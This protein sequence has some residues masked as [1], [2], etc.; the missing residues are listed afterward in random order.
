MTTDV[1]ATRRALR[2]AEEAAAV[3]KYKSEIEALGRCPR[4]LG[5][6]DFW[7][8]VMGTCLGALGMLLYLEFIVGVKLP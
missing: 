8:A 1:E 6:W 5:H 4:G 7:S 3:L 2:D